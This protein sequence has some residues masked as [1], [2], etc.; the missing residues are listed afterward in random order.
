MS[1]FSLLVVMLFL[2][3]FLLLSFAIR[4]RDVV[5]RHC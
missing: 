1:L 2:S 3:V 4:Q 5:C